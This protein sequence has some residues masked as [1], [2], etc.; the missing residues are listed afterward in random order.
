MLYIVI[1]VLLVLLFL[2]VFM[3]LILKQMLAATGK[4]IEKDAGRLFGAYDGL[5]EQKS[6]QLAALKQEEADLRASIRKARREARARRKQESAPPVRTATESIAPGYRDSGFAGAYRKVKEAFDFSEEAIRNRFE[7]GLSEPDPADTER[8][9]LCREI[10]RGLHFE[11]VYRLALM[12]EEQQRAVLLDVLTREERA[13][14]EAWSAEAHP[15]DAAAFAAYLD[16]EI[17]RLSDEVVV[18][19]A[20]D[21]PSI[22]EGV[23]IYYKNRLY[24]YSI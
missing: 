16:A 10:R 18:R 6:A 4:Q 8:L 12:P 5:L 21:D 24:D 22:C 9:S 2:N 13:L 11:N 19:T 14:Y 15:A 20:E 3:L 23:K 1:A 7:E 17:R